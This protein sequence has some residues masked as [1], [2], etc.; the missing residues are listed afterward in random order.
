MITGQNADQLLEQ[1]LIIQG[2]QLTPEDKA[3]IAQLLNQEEKEINYIQT[4]A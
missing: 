3:T 2:F 4:E 1:V